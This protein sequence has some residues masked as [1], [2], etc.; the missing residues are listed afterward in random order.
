LR[1]GVPAAEFRSQRYD[2][3]DG[4]G[5][6]VL[7]ITGLQQDQP[8]GAQ[9]IAI[10][11]RPGDRLSVFARFPVLAKFQDDFSALVSGSPGLGSG[12]DG[13]VRGVA[14]YVYVVFD[15]VSDAHWQVFVALPGLRGVVSVHVVSVVTPR[16]SPWTKGSPL[17]AMPHLAGGNSFVASW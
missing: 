5:K 2:G 6:P 17:R 13:S 9:E 15:S 1:G 8:G 10:G 4:D 3:A 12:L 14:G 7:A 11:Y 16:F